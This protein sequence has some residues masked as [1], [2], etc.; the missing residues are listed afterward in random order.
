MRP[1]RGLVRFQSTP[2]REGERAV[3]VASMPRSALFQSTPSREGERRLRFCACR[4]TTFQS[5]PSREGELA[6]AAWRVE[7]IEFQSTP[8]REGEPKVPQ[9]GQGANQCFNPHPRARVNLT[10]SIAPPVP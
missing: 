10:R 2:S 9:R 4:A 1:V 7:G 8:S 3:I 5:T 6:L